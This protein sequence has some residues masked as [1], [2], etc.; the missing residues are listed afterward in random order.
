[1]YGARVR[2]LGITQQLGVIG[3]VGRARAV[4]KCTYCIEYRKEYRE[5]DVCGRI[6][7][8]V[9][10]RYFRNQLSLTNRSPMR[11]AG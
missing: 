7:R 4:L 9:G 10:T 1:M 5:D 11:D 8:T 6:P 3:I 2:R